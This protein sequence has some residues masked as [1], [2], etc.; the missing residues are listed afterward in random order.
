[1]VHIDHAVR[2]MTVQELAVMTE[3]FNGVLAPDQPP[4]F[5]RATTPRIARMHLLHHHEQELE[6]V[7]E[8]KEP[9]GFHLGKRITFRKLMVKLVAGNT[10]GAGYTDGLDTFILA[11]KRTNYDPKKRLLTAVVKSRAAVI[12]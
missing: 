8:A 1:M 4:L 12:A 10:V 2:E 7:L 5:L 11:V 6:G 9:P 3:Y